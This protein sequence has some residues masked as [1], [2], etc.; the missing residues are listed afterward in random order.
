MNILYGDQFSIS[1]GKAG[2]LPKILKNE[3]FHKIL[4]VSNST[5]VK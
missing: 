1:A 4:L 2:K 5:H 3:I